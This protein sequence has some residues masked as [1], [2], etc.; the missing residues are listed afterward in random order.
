M[1]IKLLSIDTKLEKDQ[2]KG[3]KAREFRKRQGET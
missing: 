1:L 2:F 3:L